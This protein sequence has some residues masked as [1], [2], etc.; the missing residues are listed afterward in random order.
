MNDDARTLPD[1]DTTADLVDALEWLRSRGVVSVAE[2]RADQAAR[3][4]EDAG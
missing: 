3:T 1:D 2:V 4:L